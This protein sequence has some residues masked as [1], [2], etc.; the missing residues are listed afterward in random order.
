[1][2]TEF[3]YPAVKIIIIDMPSDVFIDKI[4][5]CPTKPILIV[6]HERSGTHLMIDTLRR[7]F[8][9]CRSWKFPFERN[10][11]LY[12]NIDLILDGRSSRYKT[13]AKRVLQRAPRI[14]IKTHQFPPGTLKNERGHGREIP[15]EWFKVLAENTT[16]IC[17]C[18]D[19][20]DVMT[21]YCQYRRVFDSA[22]RCSIGQFLRQEDHGMS[23]AKL[24]AHHVRSWMRVPGVITVS[25]DALLKDPQAT[26]KKL[27]Q[28][29]G[30]EPLWKQPL[31]PRQFKS[32]WHSR[33]ARL[34]SMRPE[35]S[36]IVVM[37]E[38]LRW[39]QCFTPEDRR[40]F[41]DEAGDLL[42]ELGYE[43]SDTWVRG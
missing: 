8:G 31:L 9:Q 43:T 21:S 26:L 34:F 20:R 1:M 25:T 4:K 16:M 39:R 3:L 40:F 2:A 18:R 23:R 27:G 13:A 17:V 37:G 6:T 11:R 10:D 42:T 38:K 22:A 12:I 19:G 24:W 7:H 14:L 30:M 29:L 33:R 36:A 32:V 35:S 28:S 5:G 41:H 15:E